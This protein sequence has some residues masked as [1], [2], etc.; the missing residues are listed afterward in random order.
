MSAAS[1]I[2]ASSQPV[3]DVASA[4]SSTRVRLTSAEST[5]RPFVSPHNLLTEHRVRVAACGCDCSAIRRRSS[6]PQSSTHLPTLRHLPSW[7]MLS[8]RG[9]LTGLVVATG[10]MT[11]FGASTTGFSERSTVIAFQ[12]E[13][14]RFAKLLGSVAAALTIAIFVVNM[15]LWRTLL[16][17]LLF[18]HVA[19]FATIR[20]HL[21][22]SPR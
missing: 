6:S 3:E 1:W 18:H 7:A 2:G 15:V 8:I 10:A 16:D 5:P 20:E 4:L 13:L 12:L 9:S 17:A 22:A 21:F 11:A 14:S 19:S